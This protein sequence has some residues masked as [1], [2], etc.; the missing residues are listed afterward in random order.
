MTMSIHRSPSLQLPETTMLDV[1]S[2]RRK[3]KYKSDGDADDERSDLYRVARSTTKRQRLS[4]G[5]RKNRGSSSLPPQLK[6]NSS[7][8]VPVPQDQGHRKGDFTSELKAANLVPIP[9]PQ[10]GYQVSGQNICENQ[11][12]RSTDQSP[13]HPMPDADPAPL[14]QKS[15][16]LCN[17]DKSSWHS[18]LPSIPSSQRRRSSAGLDFMSITDYMPPYVCEIPQI[19]FSPRPPPPLPPHILELRFEV[20]L[21]K[22]HRLRILIDNY[23]R[24]HNRTVFAFWKNEELLQGMFGFVNELQQAFNEYRP[25]VPPR[26]LD[27]PFHVVLSSTPL[28]CH[29]IERYHKDLGFEYFG[30]FGQDSRDH[31]SAW[32]VPYGI[33]KDCLT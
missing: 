24:W 2:D 25:S 8:L 18:S 6:H 7:P 21:W 15:P 17:G 9:G 1:G 11:T 3:R 30:F 27:T 19:L 29:L 22:Y 10:P 31:Y 23:Q 28:L 26:I 5:E 16:G 20:V 14:D 32:H 33:S 13:D 12:R 4:D